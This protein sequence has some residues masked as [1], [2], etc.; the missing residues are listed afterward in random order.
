[1]SCEAGDVII[2]DEAGVNIF[3]REWQTKMNKAL[4]KT[5]Q[6]LGYK[7]LGIILTFPSIMFVDKAL[8]RL[9]NY[10]LL[11]EGF[12]KEHEISFCK[13]YYNLP[14][15]YILGTETLVPFTIFENKYRIDASDLVFH[16]PRLASQYEEYA[17]RRKDQL[18]FE[19]EQDIIAMTGKRWEDVGDS[20]NYFIAERLQKV[21][22]GKI[23]KK[24]LYQLY[25]QFCNE[26]GLDPV[27]KKVF[28][29]KLKAILNVGEKRNGKHHFWVGIIAKP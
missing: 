29:A 20:V 1:M 23:S 5:F 15:N 26:H 3:A 10:I 19:L 16:K 2:F 12:D 13:A 6:I 22:E 7:H 9:F 18:L 24:E 11:A 21:P 17:K 14:Q 27:G 8:R 4:A 28:G 25:L